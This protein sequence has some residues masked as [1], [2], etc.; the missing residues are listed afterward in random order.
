M[1]ILTMVL[2]F[3]WA[4]ILLAQQQ[5]QFIMPIWF[6]DSIGNKDTIWVGGDPTS[7]YQNINPLEQ[8]TLIELRSHDF[9]TYNNGVYFLRLTDENGK[10][11]VVKLLKI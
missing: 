11:Y 10:F 7:S 8:L 4:G 9:S 1:K 6:E 2:I 5:P 3:G